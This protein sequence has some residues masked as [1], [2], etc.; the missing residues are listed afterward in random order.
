MFSATRDRKGLIEMFKGS[1]HTEDLVCQPI[2]GRDASDMNVG[3]VLSPHN[4]C[5]M[6][7]V[8]LRKTVIVGKKLGVDVTEEQKRAR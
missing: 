5:L 7:T 4:G 3:S 2:L 8:E 1:L 6:E